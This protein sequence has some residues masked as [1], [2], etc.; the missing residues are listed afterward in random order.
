M[1]ETGNDETL[2]ALNPEKTELV[3]AILNKS[4]QLKPFIL[5]LKPLRISVERVSGYRTSPSENCANIQTPE[6]E[7]QSINYNAPGLS[8][9]TFRLSLG[10]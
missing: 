9:T 1:I 7:N 3:V 2:A 4:D 10:K 6:I 8:L 5:N